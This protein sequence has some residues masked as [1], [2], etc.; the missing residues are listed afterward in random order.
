VILP[1][2]VRRAATVA[3]RTTV[4]VAVGFLVLV[5]VGP[6][7]GRYQVLPVL[8]DSMAPGMPAGALAVSV[9]VP[10]GEVHVGDV[11]T[12]RAPVG[13]H[14]VVTHRVIE[15]V[16]GGAHP[17]VRTRGDANEAADP[18]LARLDDDRAWRV[19]AV[20][21]KA[22]LAVLALRQAAPRLAFTVI[23][24]ILLAVLWLVWIWA[25]AGGP[26]RPEVELPGAQATG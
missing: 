15:V 7:T 20:V 8:S 11:V 13:A 17:V 9:P 25:P 2:V 12:L 6:R 10:A 14:E 19:S 1:A 24:P 3:S 4:V 21:P 22:G 5:A 26:E 16:E 23:A 18:W